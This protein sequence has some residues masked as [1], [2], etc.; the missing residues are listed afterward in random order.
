MI[1][2]KTTPKKTMTVRIINP[3]FAKMAAIIYFSQA[4]IK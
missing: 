2:R 3:N 4:M 1:P